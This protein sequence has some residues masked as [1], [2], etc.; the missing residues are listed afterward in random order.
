MDTR[1]GYASPANARRG[2]AGRSGSRRPSARRAPARDGR[3]VLP[4]TWVDPWR[5]G[6]AGDRRRTRP[7]RLEMIDP[8]PGVGGIVLCGGRSSRM[9]RPKAYLP[10]G[11]ETLLQRTVRVL[12]EVVDPIVVVAAPDQDVPGLPPSVLVARDDREYLGP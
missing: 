6:P 12:G 4:G 9:G 7:G 5:R 11:N 10:F 8:I 2:A 1:R 3:R